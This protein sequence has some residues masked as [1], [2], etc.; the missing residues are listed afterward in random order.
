VQETAR[1]LRA[2]GGHVVKR[3]YPGMGHTIN[4]D[5]IKRVRTALA[6]LLHATAPAETIPAS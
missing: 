4:D 5:E 1:S 6:G 2:L 3:I